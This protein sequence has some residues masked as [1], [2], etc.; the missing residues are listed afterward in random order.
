MNTSPRLRS[1]IQVAT[2][3][4][5]MASGGVL[6]EVREA[7]RQTE[8][9]FCPH[10]EAHAHLPEILANPPDVAI[11]DWPPCLTCPHNCA[12]ALHKSCPNLPLLLLGA[13]PKSSDLPAQ[14]ASH[15]VWC[16]PKPVAVDHLRWRL[17]HLAVC[18][19]AEGASDALARAVLRDHALRSRLHHEWPL[20]DDHDVS[21]AV[22]DAVLSY[23]S[24]PERFDPSRGVS[25]RN[26]VHVLAWRHIKDVF[27]RSKPLAGRFLSLEQ[28]AE[29]A[30]I[31]ATS[32][33]TPADLA[34]L[35]E[36]ALE[37]A[38]QSDRRLESLKAFAN[39]RLSATDQA[40]LSLILKG[41]HDRAPFE[42]ALGVANLP[43]PE[44]RQ[45]VARAVNR[46]SHRLK[47]WA[48]RWKHGEGP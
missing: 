33:S 25:F 28:T 46:V 6:D 12:L 17:L 30:G 23:L 44:K 8:W 7:D 32:L 1:L 29:P 9:E 47:R 11:L 27:R 35:E 40:V 19:G 4:F 10:E 48:K 39:K 26:F 24:R 16:V 22:N 36:E 43:E 37:Q 18:A 41:D 21:Q 34:M 2:L 14:A 42:E 5:G 45:T 38:T 15:L 3:C 13:E 20:A 31:K